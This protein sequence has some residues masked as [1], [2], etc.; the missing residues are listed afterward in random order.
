MKDITRSFAAIE[1]ELRRQYDVSYKPSE[2]NADG[3]FHSIE[4]T[5][6]KKDLQVRAP[7]GYY[8]PRQ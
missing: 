7:R 2:F 8:A 3:R 5:T 1:Y 4:I 6:L